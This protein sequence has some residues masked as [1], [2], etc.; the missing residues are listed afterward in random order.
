MDRR[1]FLQNVAV[2]SVAATSLSSG[3]EA[4]AALLNETEP[5]TPADIEGH[6]LVCTFNSDNASW[7]VYEDLRTREGVLTFISSRGQSRVLRK[8]AEADRESEAKRVVA[9]VQLARAGEPKEIQ[10]KFRLLRQNPL[11]AVMVNG[12]PATLAGLHND[13][14]T[15]QTGS[16]KGFEVVGEFG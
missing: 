1:H 11:R 4:V 2:A 8:S 9:K 16:E 13:S 7:K 10:V 6:T 14:V 3:T 12:R 15:I 5:A